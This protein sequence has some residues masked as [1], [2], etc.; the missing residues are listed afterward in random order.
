MP[1]IV[2]RMGVLAGFVLCMHGAHAGDLAWPLDCVVGVDC[3]IGFPDTDKDGK[4]FNCGKPGYIGHEGSDI[5]ISRARM[6]AGTDVYAAADGVVMWVFDGKFDGCPDRSPDCAPPDRPL[7]ANLNSGYA[8]CTGLGPYC[9]DGRG[10][11]FWCFFGGN[12]VVIRHEGIPGVFAT[13]YDH[14]RR[15]SIRVARG[16]RVRQ[17]QVIAKV[18]SAGK[19]TGPH[20][21]FEVWGRTYY[22]PVDPWAG[23]CGPNTGPSLW[24]NPAQPWRRN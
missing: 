13:R 22:D 4:A 9:R 5:S 15:N 14:L 10:R 18:G 19:S 7:A 12:V 21:H 2:D 8:V 6:D 3:S 20:L 23:N 24:K 17:G 16:E 11:C 1:T